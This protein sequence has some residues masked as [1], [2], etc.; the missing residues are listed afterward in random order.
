MPLN[1]IPKS[2]PNP[3]GVPPQGPAGVAKP[4]VVNNAANTDAVAPV[5]APKANLAPAIAAVKQ[6]RALVKN[7]G[8]EK[9]Y[10]AAIGLA[11]A[12]AKQKA[13][14]LFAALPAITPGITGDEMVRLGLWTTAPRGVDAAMAQP[15]YVPG[16]QVMVKT[17][18]HSDLGNEQTF[19]AYKAD[20]V[21][22]VTYR[23]ELAGERGDDFLVR[24]DK[25]GGGYQEITVPKKEIYALNQPHQPVM[26]DGVV[27]DIGKRAD[28]NDPLLKAKLAQAAIE[29]DE[30][31]G[32][33][34]FARK[35]AGKI[36]G[37]LKPQKSAA[38]LQRQALKVIHDTIQMKY[39]SGDVW[40]EPGRDGGNDVGRLAIRGHGVCYDQAGVMFGML[41]PFQSLLA[42]DV[43]FVSGGTYRHAKVGDKNPFGRGAHGWLQITYR[44]SMEIR[45]CDR[46][47][48]QP[49][50]TAD[51][52]YSRW[53]D[54]YPGDT[55]R[56][57][58]EPVR[59]GDVE[60]GGRVRLVKGEREF[61]QQGVDGRDNHMSK[62]Q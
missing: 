19:L 46:T 57:P 54:R 13:L 25:A 5:A 53:G 30:I 16:R 60:M 24:V 44:P 45:I 32:Q 43:Q 48:R 18:V 61:G 26:K 20:G 4:G 47:W 58:V 2:N 1:G 38:E 14:D 42:F 40:K 12:A 6:M 35:P 29:M 49:D 51:K 39:S 56:L 9:Y 17:T 28:Y 8:L 59:Q 33:L 50:H 55:W 62:N 23:A 31:V 7:G 27:T 37:L 52:A 22:A 15:R 21:Q 34:D 36:M 3:P 41:L 11:D 10:E